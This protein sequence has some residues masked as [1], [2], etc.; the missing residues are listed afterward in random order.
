MHPVF[1]RSVP[2]DDGRRVRLRLARPG[3]AA[4]VAGLLE[5]CG[6]QARPL[7]L[8]RELAFD[9]ARRAVLCAHD[10]GLLVAV[11]AIDLHADAVPDTLIADEARAPGAGAVL[12]TALETR[13]RA[14]GRRA[15]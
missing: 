7:D 12:A 5:R 11:G 13:A 14:H 1:T 4:E 2:L 9:P 10:T 15:A 3:D 8:R 6:L